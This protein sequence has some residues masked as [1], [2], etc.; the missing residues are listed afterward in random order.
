M[1]KSLSK[2]VI[3]FLKIRWIAITDSIWTDDAELGLKIGPIVLAYYK[4]ADP[5]VL[6][7]PQYR[8]MEKREFGEAIHT[9]LV[10]KRKK[11]K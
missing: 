10:Y 11:S 3:D 1:K 5:T 9:Q 4:W 8:E 7:R 2:R 6:W